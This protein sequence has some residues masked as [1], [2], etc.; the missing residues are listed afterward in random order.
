MILPTKHLPE[1]RALLV[2][3]AEVLD[4]LDEP[5]TVS[6]LWEHF[7]DG[8]GPNAPPRTTYDWF[9]LALDML[10]TIGAVRFEDGR[11]ARSS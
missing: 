8:V 4:S 10:Y 3:G 11:L 2:L 5:R 7:R 1:G 6:G 9:V